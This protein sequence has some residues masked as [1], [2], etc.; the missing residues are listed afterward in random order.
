MLIRLVQTYSNIRRGE[1]INDCLRPNRLSSATNAV[2]A[3]RR[4]CLAPDYPAGQFRCIAIIQIC[5]GHVGAHDSWP[6]TGWRITSGKGSASS[7]Q[8]RIF[9][10][11]V[12]DR[13]QI[14]GPPLSQFKRGTNR[15]CGDRLVWR[16]N[17]MADPD[18]SPSKMHVPSS[19]SPRSRPEPR[20]KR[21]NFE[22]GGQGFESL[23]A[24][25]FNQA[26]TR[27]H[28]LRNEN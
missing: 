1:G 4:R 8:H 19:P 10:L 5:S 24:R 25:Q 20:S 12:N 11:R 27:N 21:P 9:A 6:N 18:R 22:S 28:R 2:I 7:H 14:Y 13:D 17:R 23:P 16:G 15:W 26:L 3:A